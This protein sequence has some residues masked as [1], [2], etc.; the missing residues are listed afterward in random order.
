MLNIPEGMLI[1]QVHL[2]GILFAIVGSF[3]IKGL[4]FN[5]LFSEGVMMYK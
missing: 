2:K 5:K 1:K 3:S 4:N